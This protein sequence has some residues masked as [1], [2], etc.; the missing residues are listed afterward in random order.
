MTEPFVSVWERAEVPPNEELRSRLLGALPK[1]EVSDAETVDLP[2]DLQSTTS[3]RS[4]VLLML[5]TAAVLVT[6]VGVVASNRH[7][8]PP[9]VRT[10]PSI[11]VAVTSAPTTPGTLPLCKIGE[12]V[13]AACAPPM[14]IAS[15]TTPVPTTTAAP[16]ETVLATGS[17][18]GK[19]WQ[20]SVAPSPSDSGFTC[21]AFSGSN[22]TRTF[23]FGGGGETVVAVPGF[24]AY[25]SL[26]SVGTEVPAVSVSSGETLS[27][28]KVGTVLQGG[29]SLAVTPDT[30]PIVAVAPGE[31][32]DY[33]GI[34]GAL[35]NDTTNLIKLDNVFISR[36]RDNL[37]FGSSAPFAP[38]YQYA[39]ILYRFEATGWQVGEADH[40]NMCVDAVPQQGMRPLCARLGW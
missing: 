13:S 30:N 3:K 33:A 15:T 24:M 19:N 31:R 9:L 14:T 38:G 36:C 12:P 29:I 35:A 17:N 2:I 5:A 32:C 40:M 11:T 1:S 6:I 37:A 18:D 28:S 23:C 22:V 8:S 20:L 27:V 26:A 7:A 16:I 25:V 4:R 21:L 39:Q 10:E 34:L